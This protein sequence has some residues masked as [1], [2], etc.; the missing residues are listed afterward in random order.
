LRNF[1]I[2]KTAA[3]A[4]KLLSCGLYSEELDELSKKDLISLD[5]IKKYGIDKENLKVIQ[6]LIDYDF[7]CILSYSKNDKDCIYAAADICNI[8]KENIFNL[9]KKYNEFIKKDL[10]KIRSDIILIIPYIYSSLYSE[11]IREFKHTI[12]LV[13]FHKHNIS[14]RFHIEKSISYL[15]PQLPSIDV[16]KYNNIP[17][18]KEYFNIICSEEIFNTK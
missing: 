4:R 16:I 18:K 13:D 8:K 3:N 7:K 2:D 6:S 10:D 15:W 5:D 1:E 9:D 11:L 17:F 14:R 12:I